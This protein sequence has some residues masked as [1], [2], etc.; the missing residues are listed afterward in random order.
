MSATMAFHGI[1]VRANCSVSA[2]DTN[3]R[4]G[5]PC[6]AAANFARLKSL[7]RNFQGRL[8]QAPLAHIYRSTDRRLSVAGRS[9]PRVP[10]RQNVEKWK[11]LHE[12]LA[13]NLKIY[14]GGYGRI[15]SAALFWFPKPVTLPKPVTMWPVVASNG[16]EWS[17]DAA[18]GD[19]GHD[20]GEH[21]EH[22]ATRRQ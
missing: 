20:V 14:W 10:V 16:C 15:H 11:K 3:F 9:R 19:W 1:P 21:G 6:S 22:P 7:V 17:F 5:I 12:P 13:L 4:S 2:S 18:A 8:H